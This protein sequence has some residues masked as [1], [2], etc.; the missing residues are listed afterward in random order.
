MG[1]WNLREKF[2]PYWVYIL[3]CS[4]GSYYT[5]IAKDVEKRVSTHQ[6][7]K[8][9]RYVAS[10]LPCKLV[11]SQAM[12]SKSEALRKEIEMKRL[13]HRQK[14][15]WIHHHKIRATETPGFSLGRKSHSL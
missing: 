12:D 5:G 11:Y 9:S 6:K 14:Q 13:T 3:E 1:L 10:R 7:G 8:G 15:E 2:M 4:D